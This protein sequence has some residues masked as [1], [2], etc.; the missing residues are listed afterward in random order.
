MSN[1][2]WS[3]YTKTLLIEKMLGDPDFFSTDTL[4]LSLWTGPVVDKFNRLNSVGEVVSKSYS[5]ASIGNISTSF[6]EVLGG[7]IRNAVEISFPSASDR[8]GIVQYIAI[9]DAETEGNLLFYC[10]LSTSKEVLSGDRV[11]FP[12]SSIRIGFTG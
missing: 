7:D 2:S 3:E 5:R 10:T 1:G 6:S 8:W 4:Y 11:F 9:F 12:P